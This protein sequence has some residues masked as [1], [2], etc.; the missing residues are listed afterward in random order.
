MSVRE[1]KLSDVATRI[2]AARYVVALTGAGVST[3]SGIPDFRSD[4]GLWAE[5]DPMEVSSIEGFRADAARF[6]DF[7]RDALG[8]LVHAEPSPA[9]RLLAHLEAR[10]RVQAVVT[11]NVDGLHQRAGSRHVLEVHGT[12]QTVRCLDCG[13][14]LGLDVVFE[15]PPHTAPVCPACDKAQLKPDVV[16]FGEMLPPVFAVAETE[17]R[18]ADLLLVLGTSLTVHPVAGLVPL[19]KLNGAQVV[20]LNRDATP[21]DEDADVVVHGEL[22]AMCTSLLSMLG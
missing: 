5:H 15:T 21:F 6:Y 8:P 18:Q 20:L 10:G 2:E 9:H 13:H 4:A 14:V 7:W 22:G 19:A 17:V 1:P 3:E 12:F 11:Q 16:L